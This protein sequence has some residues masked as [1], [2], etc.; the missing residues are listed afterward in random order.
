VLL[1]SVDIPPA[2][3]WEDAAARGH[4]DAYFP[5]LVARHGLCVTAVNF[6]RVL[7]AH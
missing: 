5:T 7:D 4:V 3:A 2:M 1:K 6:R